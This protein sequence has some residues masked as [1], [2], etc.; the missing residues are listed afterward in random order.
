MF[1]TGSNT[2]RTKFTENEDKKLTNYVKQLGD[3]KWKEIAKLMPGRNARQ[4]KD[5]W[6]KYL[7][8][9]INITPFT[10]EEDTKLLT[11]YNQIGPKWT[12][13]SKHFNNRTDNNLK[14]RY[15]LLMRHKKK[16]E[17]NHSTPDE[18]IFTESLKECQEFLSFLNN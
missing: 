11:L 12:Q 14:S 18:N 3:S 6:E 16:A 15:K 1:R 10:D 9:K 4:C 5:R 8:P 2:V 13:I 17:V 7:A